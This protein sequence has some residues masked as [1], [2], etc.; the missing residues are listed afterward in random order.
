[1]S[2]V[3]LG[4]KMNWPRRK[5][6]HRRYVEDQLRATRA[7]SS[8][9]YWYGVCHREGVFGSFRWQLEALPLSPF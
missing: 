3:S 2:G 8:S 7:L 6:A 4:L 9:K 1:M 5:C